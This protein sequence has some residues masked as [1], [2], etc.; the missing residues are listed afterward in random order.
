[1]NAGMYECTNARM[2]ECTNGVFLDAGMVYDDDARWR[3]C[4]THTHTHTHKAHKQSTLQSL[5]FRCSSM[6]APPA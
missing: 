1:M 2:H 5:S 3:T 4:M 6:P